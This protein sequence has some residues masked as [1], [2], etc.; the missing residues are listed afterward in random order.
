MK[1]N[2]KTPLKEPDTAHNP[3]SD[4]LFADEKSSTNDFRF[5]EKTAAVFDDMVNRSVPYYEEMQRMTGEVAI[6]FAVSGTNLVDIGCATGTTLFYL[7]KLIEPGVRFVGL[8]DSH[9]MLDKA[10]QK[11]ETSHSGREFEL[12]QVDIHQGMEIENASVVTLILTLQF[13]RP[14]YRERIIQKIFDGMNDQGILI[15]FEKIIINDSF[16]NRLFIKY[17]YEMKKRKGYSEVEISKKREALENVLIP[18][19]PEENMTL[20]SKAGFSH[21]E[22]IFRWYNFTGIIAVK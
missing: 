16:F 14:L 7:D 9:E 2:K 12:Q 17:Y 22:E 10:K 19:R 13:V 3:P 20:L 1:F 4:Q 5:D 18:Y 11:I 21:I 8:D 15:I 6:D